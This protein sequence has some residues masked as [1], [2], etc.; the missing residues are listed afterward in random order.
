M[1]VLKF[2]CDQAHHLNTKIISEKFSEALGISKDIVLKAEPDK[3]TVK[4][5]LGQKGAKNISL[6]IEITDEDII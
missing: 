2:T 3:D 6:S 4:I 5:Y 1:L